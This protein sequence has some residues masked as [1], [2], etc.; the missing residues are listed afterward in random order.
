[1]ILSYRYVSSEVFSQV[2]VYIFQ[3]YTVYWVIHSEIWCRSNFWKYLTLFWKYLQEAT[4][5]W[6]ILNKSTLKHVMFLQ[7]QGEAEMV[8][9]CTAKEVLSKTYK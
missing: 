2:T 3:A 5:T 8:S 1:M 4:K 6:L 7:I 9:G